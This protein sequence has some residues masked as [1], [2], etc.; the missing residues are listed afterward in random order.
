MS[1][2]AILIAMLGVAIGLAVMIVS[3]AVIIGFKSQVKEKVI[4]FGSHIQI[5]NFDAVQSYE[6]LPIVIDDF[7]LTVLSEDVDVQH[8][9]RYTTKLGMIKTE[10]AF[11]G[12][13]LKGV[14]PEYDLQFL[15]HNLLEGEMPLFSNTENKEQALLSKRLC[16]RLNLKLGDKI[17]LYFIQKDNVR[18][19]RLF[20]KGIYETNLT[21]YDDLFLFTDIHTVN[22]L[23]QW[24]EH[25]VSGVEIRLSDYDHLEEATY[26]LGNQLDAEEDALG[27][28]YFVRNIEQLN[29]QIFDWLGLLDFNVWIILILMIGVAGFTVISG[30][31]ILII[32][33]TSMIGVLKALGATNVTIQ[34]IFL[35]LSIF[36]IG[37]GMIIGNVIGLGFCYVQHKFG[38]ISLDPSTYYMDSVPVYFDFKLF[39]LVNFVTFIVAV[40]ILVGPSFVISKV[41]PSDSMRFE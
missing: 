1:R 39:L 13:V 29:P 4:G 17:Y 8:I 35:W 18:A 6:T 31:L 20:V 10:D 33:R 32:E 36:L 19:R 16:D 5:S 9:Q 30:L 37:R 2:P 41:N 26:R 23:N 38:L 27:G 24:D 12:V 21:M 25:Q 40:A 15:S 3:L 14:G 11:E 28:I 34:K 22:R 7:I